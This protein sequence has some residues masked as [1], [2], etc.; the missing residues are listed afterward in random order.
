MMRYLL[1]LLLLAGCVDFPTAFAD[2]IDER[3][4]AEQPFFVNCSPLVYKIL[5]GTTG[6]CQALNADS[7]LIAGALPRWV[8]SNP[9]CLLIDDLGALAV[10]LAQCTGVNIFAF[11][12]N[13]SAAVQSGLSS[14]SLP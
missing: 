12:P 4:V 2:Y 13:N 7:T 8:S 3:T 11:G 5:L 10:G 6:K 14:D 1:L 9:A